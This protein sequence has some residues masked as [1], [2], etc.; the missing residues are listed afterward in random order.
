MERFTDEEC[1]AIRAGLVEVLAVVSQADK[2]GLI[3]WL[4][5]ERATR[6]SLKGLPEPLLSI[7]TSTDLDDS[8]YEHPACG[9]AVGYLEPALAM[10]EA[11]A[12]E[13]VDP[14]KVAVLK[15][16]QAVAEATRGVSL[17]EQQIL[18]EIRTFFGDNFD[19]LAT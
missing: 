13:L 11:K 10:V 1:V 12:P 18:V 5:E 16:T 17:D 8:T 19:L 3:G 6:K 4:K 15:S 2:P 7:V 14:F 9:T